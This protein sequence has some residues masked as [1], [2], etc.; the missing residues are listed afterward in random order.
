MEEI[1]LFEEAPETP[2]PSPDSLAF[3]K[4]EIA[5]AEATLANPAID[6][7]EKA[8]A[9]AIK[10]SCEDR[11]AVMAMKP[12]PH[13]RPCNLN[14]YDRVREK[15]IKLFDNNAQDADDFLAVQLEKEDID[16]KTLK[17]W[18][19]D[20]YKAISELIIDMATAAKNAKRRKNKKAKPEIIATEAAVFTAPEPADRPK[21]MTESLEPGDYVPGNWYQQIMTAAERQGWPEPFDQYYAPTVHYQLCRKWAESNG[22]TTTELFALVGPLAHA[23]GLSQST[24]SREVIEQLEQKLKLI[25][26]ERK[27]LEE[28][29]LFGDVELH[30]GAATD[31]GTGEVLAPKQEPDLIQSADIPSTSTSLGHVSDAPGPSNAQ[32]ATTSTPIGAT[33]LTPEQEQMLA[34][35][36]AKLGLDRPPLINNL[37]DVH[38]ALRKRIQLLLEHAYLQEEYK[39]T[40]AEINGKLAAW[41][42]VYEAQLEAYHRMNP[43]ASGKTTKT[44]FGDL[45]LADKGASVSISTDDE[46]IQQAWL[47]ATFQK[48]PALAQAW[49]IAEKA[50]QYTR[51]LDK[52]KAW[53]EEAVTNGKK[54]ECPWLEYKG[55]VKNA[56][57]VGPSPETFAKHLKEGKTTLNALEDQLRG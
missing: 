13:A 29:D 32:D 46:A 30:E 51:N 5:K 18:N 38:K 41:E 3:L 17:G 53:Y 44:L 57:S 16:P 20:A 54:P 21:W 48:N 26:Q 7:F 4:G 6:S 22:F 52:I 31:T 55:P 24:I 34:E 25:L 11:I 12:S 47:R 40:M 19:W 42:K 56:F 9:K 28:L 10:R 27:P 37:K 39:E 49:E 8:H 36:R 35:C 14:D 15:A 1:D 2:E 43:P 23:A 45:K 50:P 33:A